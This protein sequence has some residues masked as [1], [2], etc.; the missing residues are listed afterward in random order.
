M[1]NDVLPL[2]GAI[3]YFFVFVFVWYTTTM[4]LIAGVISYIVCIGIMTGVFFAVTSVEKTKARLWSVILDDAKYVAIWFPVLALT[5]IV[6]PR[7]RRPIWR[8]DARG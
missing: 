4:F 6:A 8:P 2:R 1:H 5:L 3:P 7:M